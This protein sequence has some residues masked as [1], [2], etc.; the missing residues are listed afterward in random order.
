MLDINSLGFILLFNRLRMC[1]L[2]VLVGFFFIG[3]VDLWISEY[4]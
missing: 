4:D 1:V 2:V 3:V